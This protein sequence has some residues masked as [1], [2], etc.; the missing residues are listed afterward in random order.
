AG[1][2]A[3]LQGKGDDRRWHVLIDGGLYGPAALTG[4]LY[5]AL[6]AR[7]IGIRLE[8]VGQQLKE[9]RTDDATV[10]P[11]AR[12]AVQVERERR[13]LHDLEALG[14]G[15][16][17]A[18]LDAVVH[19]LDVVACARLPDVQVPALGRQRPENGLAMLHGLG[20][21]AHHEAVAILQSPHAA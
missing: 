21:A 6:E 8:R 11:K 5:P 17:Q 3:R 10:A 20:R 2:E 12:D 18:V 1:T 4:V 15:L 14:V 13:R 19:H 7:E 9:P 16:H